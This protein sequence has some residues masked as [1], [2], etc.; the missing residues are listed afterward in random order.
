[1]RMGRAARRRGHADRGRT[2]SR[3]RH[4]RRAP[5]TPARRTAPAAARSTARVVPGRG[6]RAPI[7]GVITRWRV[8]AGAEHDAGAPPGPARDPRRSATR[9]TV[10]PPADSRPPCSRADPD[11]G[12]R[13]IALGA[14]P[15][16][17]EGSSQT[18]SRAAPRLWDPP[19]GPTTRA[20]PT[21]GGRPRCG[22]STPTS[23]PTPTPTGSATRRRTTARGRQPRPGRPRPRRPRR[24][25]RP[26]APTSPARR[27]PG[28][29]RQPAEPA[30][31]RALPHPDDRERSRADRADRA[32][33]RRRQRPADRQRVRRR[34]HDLR[35][36]GPP[37]TRATGRRPA[38]TSGGPRCSPAP[39]TPAG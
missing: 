6:A 1:M 34:R 12:R 38:P 23:S 7:S 31:D 29:V 20:P 22:W 30:A 27:L 10:T 3:R 32:R 28:G 39:S 9:P 15:R 35:R 21:L 33:R 11:H 16:R 8:T 24:R 2:R 5:L 37:R 4:D 18:S 25:L 26:R 19:L 13:P 14:A 17:P 36:C